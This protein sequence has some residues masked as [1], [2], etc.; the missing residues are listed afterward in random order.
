MDPG[1]QHY[2]MYVPHGGVPAPQTSSLLP[3]YPFD[4]ATTLQVELLDEGHLPPPITSIAFDTA[5]ELL[6]CGTEDGWLTAMYAPTLARH[7]SVEAH[8]HAIRQIL[9]IGSGA[10]SLCSSSV[11]FHTSSGVRTLTC[12]ENDGERSALRCMAYQHPSGR[13]AGKL[14]VGRTTAVVEQY[15]MTRGVLVKSAETNQGCEVMDWG[16]ARSLLAI[17]GVEGELS[18]RDV[19]NGLRQELVTSAHGSGAVTGLTCK[20]DLVVTCG[21]TKRAGQVVIDQFIKVFDVRY[22]ARLLNQL[23][24]PTGPVS[25]AF[26]HGYE[27]PT[28]SIVSAT[29]SVQTLH[30]TNPAVAPFNY[31]IDTHGATILGQSVSSTGELVAFNDDSGWVHMYCSNEDPYVNIESYSTA[32]VDEGVLAQQAPFELPEDLLDCGLTAEEV[33]PAKV[34]YK[35]NSSLHGAK[36]IET[37]KKGLPDIYSRVECNRSAMTA[38]RRYEEF[39][40][41]TYNKTDFQD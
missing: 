24:C 37:K 28:V 23:Q 25:V 22:N 4:A 9:P 2:N 5:E 21:L 33:N 1:A 7:V 8:A 18:F 30:L 29:G 27:S 31:Q 40:F 26:N 17:G 38:E 32:P 13:I 12:G 19:R 6:W 39:D 34:M 15:D 35:S 36:V 3:S 20:G 16:T 11:A 41:S 10:L 14:F